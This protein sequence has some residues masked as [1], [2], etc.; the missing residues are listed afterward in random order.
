MSGKSINFEDKKINKSNFYENKKLFNVHDL[1]VNKILVSKKESYSAK[2]SCRYFIGYNDDDVIRPLCI[3]LSQMVGYVK[4]FD[5]NKIMSF[6]VGDI[7]LLKKYT[8]IWEKIG[9]L[10][11]IEFDSEPV[12][13]DNDKYIKTK[14]KMYEDRVNTNF[15]GK[16]VSKENASFKCLSLI[17]LDSVIRVNKKYCPQTFLEESKHVIRKNKMENL[18]NDDLDISSSNESDNEF[19]NETDNESDNESDDGIDESSD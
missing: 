17:V 19:D 11:N 1:N 18:I 13:G 9:N 10:M 14:R 6:K 3:K 8:K 16:K 5:S 7:T 12:S 2:N 15:Q 4:H